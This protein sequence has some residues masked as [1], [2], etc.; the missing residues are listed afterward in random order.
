MSIAQVEIIPIALPFRER[1]RTA[2]G[3]LA[4]R[5]MIVVRLVTDSGTVGLGEA[6]PL[7]LRGGPSLGQVAAELTACVPALT[8]VETETPCGREPGEIRAW[9]WDLLGGCRARGAGSQA[10]AALDIALHDLSGR[11]SGMPMWRLLGAS[12][13]RDVPCNASIDAAAPERAG[14]LAAELRSA[15]FETFKVKVG[16]A[17]D[18][19]RVG[20]V[21]D[22]VG[23]GPRIRIDANGAWTPD[24]AKA[25]LDRLDPLGIELSEQPCAE[26]D[27]L[28]RV[29]AA[30][31]I[32]IVADESVNS[33]EE[34][35]QATAVG[36]CDAVTIKLAKVGGPLEALRVAAAAPS[37]LSSALDGPIGI[38]AAIHTTQVLP[39]EGYASELAHGLATLGMF[40][41]TY[42]PLDGLFAAE[43]RPPAAPGLGVDVDPRDLE[44]FALR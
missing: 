6:V 4:A 25:M 30:T 11:L 35:E 36:A 15:G 44:E 22:A 21:R 39:S 43:V 40:G 19:E 10:V 2:S 24:E 12:E 31:E 29:R 27:G 7:S 18:V 28:A 1:Y 37:Y 32:P 9:I 14:A 3:A 16:T 20:A 42:A 8:A 17:G 5:S 23:P 33:A 13:M 38:A 26:L 41:S 34:A